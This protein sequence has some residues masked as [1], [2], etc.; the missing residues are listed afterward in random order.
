MFHKRFNFLIV[1]R[2]LLLVGNVFL[3]TWIFG[4]ER[5]FF[6][7]LIVTAALIGQVVELIYFLNHTNRQLTR[8]FVSIKHADDSVSFREKKLGKSFKLLNESFTD[9]IESFKKVKIEKE[10]QYQILQNIVEQSHVGIISL[11]GNKITLMNS[12]AERLLNLEG[13]KNRDLFAQTNP[14]IA[15]ELYEIGDH[16]RKLIDVRLHGESRM[17]SVDINTIIIQEKAYKLIT[18]Q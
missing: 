17:I 2:V 6:N 12:T 8:F 3:L 5:L 9:I 7:Q 4:D 14:D 10:I 15:K 1:L 11:E 16:G 13:V 18:L